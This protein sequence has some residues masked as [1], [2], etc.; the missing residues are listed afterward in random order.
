MVICS[1]SIGSGSVESTIKQIGRRVKISGAQ[2]NRHNFAQVLKHRCAYL[3]VCVELAYAPK[4]P[5]VL[6]A[7]RI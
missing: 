3:I 6:A 4:A 2:W 1:I 5:L 7:E